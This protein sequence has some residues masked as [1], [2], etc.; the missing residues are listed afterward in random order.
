[1]M[2]YD[3]ICGDICGALSCIN[4][5]YLSRRLPA[6]PPLGTEGPLYNCLVASNPKC[7]IRENVGS[8]QAPSGTL[9]QQKVL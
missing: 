9:Q 4:G 1:M 8:W 5:R 2:L 3:A 7:V 6:M